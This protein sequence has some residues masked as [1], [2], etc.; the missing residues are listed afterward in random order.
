MQLKRFVAP[1]AAVAAVGAMAVAP[2]ALSGAATTH[3]FLGVTG[4]TAIQAL[5]TTVESDFTSRSGVDTNNT[6]VQNS[7]TLAT[8]VVPNVATVSAVS[9]VAKTTDVAGGGGRVTVGAQAGLVNVLDGLVTAQAITSSA[10]AQVD[11]N[12]NP[13]GDVTSQLVNLKIGNFRVPASVPKNFHVTIPGVANIWANYSMVN[14]GASGSGT[15]VTWGAGLYVGLLQQRGNFPAGTFIFVNPVYSAIST[16]TPVTGAN[17]FGTAFGT[18]V[19]VQGGGLLSAE[20]GP[21][22]QISQPWDGTDGL[23]K[24]NTT[25][26]ANV[27]DVLFTSAITSTAK[28]VKNPANQAYS[29]MTTQLAGVNVL[30][31]VITADALTGFARVE[32]LATGGTRAIADTSLVNLKVLGKPIDINTNAN[33]VINIANVGQLIVRGQHTSVSSDGLTAQSLVTVL[34]LRITVAQNNGKVP[35]GAL[36]QVGF[37]QASMVIPSAG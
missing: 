22:A 5:G 27:Q 15:I 28:G 10:Y 18:K 31:G 6:G 32:A 34:Q 29:Q 2:G 1:L 37:A 24:K 4:G 26:T 16:V 20:S 19:T 35:V 11:A 7:N 30:N 25:A 12:N 13:V 23:V 3:H 17:I 8:A 36:I 9:T 21:T 14:P 33:T